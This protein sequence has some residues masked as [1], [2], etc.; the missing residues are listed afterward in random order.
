VADL[1]RRMEQIVAGSDLP[2]IEGLLL[3]H[4]SLST[5]Q[6]GSVM[7]SAQVARWLRDHAGP[8]IKV[9][10]VDRGTQELV[11]QVQTGGWPARDP[12]QQGQ[13]NFSLRKYDP[14]GRPDQT[15]G[16]EWKIDVIEA[17]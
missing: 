7:D 17:E 9:T 1:Q 8:G 15:G 13:V 4:V 11:V 2:G 3:D 5:P 14:S 16:G 6:G 12:I 10:Q